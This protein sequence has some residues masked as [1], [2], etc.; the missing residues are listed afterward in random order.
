MASTLLTVSE[1]KEVIPG[2]YIITLKEDVSLA[3]HV[4]ST[5]AS[6][7]STPSNITHEFGI[8]NG[9]AGEFCDADLNELRAHPEIASIEQDS[10]VKTCTVVT[11]SV[12]SPN[13]PEQPDRTLTDF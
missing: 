13:L 4:N 12:P 8:I 1:A 3:A 10:V 2:R 11:Q 5:Q 7:A 9:Y 6:I